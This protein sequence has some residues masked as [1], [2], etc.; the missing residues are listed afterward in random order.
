VRCVQIV[1]IAARVV[2]PAEFEIVQERAGASC[3]LRLRGALDVAAVP[4]LDAE[5]RRV[6][7]DGAGTLT[8]DLGGLTF[9]DSTGLAA[10]IHAG[11]VCAAGARGFEL[12]PGPRAVQRPFEITGL[13]GVLPFSGGA[14]PA[15]R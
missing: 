9:I 6:V 13:D 4:K 5:V 7:A 8:L 14:E 12:L 2:D 10:I 1:S 15:D 3:V 11:S